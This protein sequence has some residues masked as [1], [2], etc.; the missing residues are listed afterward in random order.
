MAFNPLYFSDPSRNPALDNAMAP[1]RPVNLR[2]DIGVALGQMPLPPEIPETAAEPS[3]PSFRD[4]A[5]A[6][7]NSVANSIPRDTPSA[8]GQ[9]AGG[10]ARG[11]A[12]VQAYLQAVTGQATERRE[13]NTDR[14][15]NRDRIR[16]TTEAE[17]ARGRSEDAQAA[18]ASQPPSAPTPAADNWELVPGAPG[19]PQMQRNRRDGTVKPV[20]DPQGRPVRVPARP[21]P[22][23]RTGRSG[24]TPRTGTTPP[25]RTRGESDADYWER[26]K[27]ILGADAATAYVRE[28]P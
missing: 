28:H 11:F 26:L 20:L 21:E 14:E 8:F 13:A 12:G 27:P 23:P 10:L 6:F 22:A 15:L 1:G 3:G 24:V 9:F 2:R 5:T 7:A 25:A 4:R 16:A 19:T 18:R 17:K